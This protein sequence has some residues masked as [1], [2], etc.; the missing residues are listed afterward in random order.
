MSKSTGRRLFG[1]HTKGHTVTVIEAPTRY[2]QRRK[3]I[4]AFW[5]TVVIVALL[6]GTVAAHYM[7]PILGGLLGIVGGAVSGAIVAVLI[8]IWP[9]LRMIWHWL[10]EI[11]LA[12]FLIYGWNTLMFATPVWLSLLILAVLVGGPAAYGPTRRAV[13][14]LF[15]CLT[16]R[17]RLR[18]CFAAFVAHNRQGTLPFILLARPTPAGERVWL[19]LRPGLS[20]HDLEQPGQVQKLAVACWAN[21]V[22]VIRASRKYAPF[23]RV[24]ITRREPLTD[25]VLSTLPDHVPAHM[26]ATGPVSPTVPPRGVNLAEVPIPRTPRA[27]NDNTHDRPRTPRNPRPPAAPP[28]DF[29]PSD[30][31]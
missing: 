13:M 23:I 11:L 19:W 29:D 3:A 2:N 10:P 4:I 27:S 25:T 17:H 15:W 31:A 26:P 21:E 22:R 5:V 12:G 30:Y 16:V 24:D 8:I 9:V 18:M 14:S 1:S 6:G 28:A 7:H 20:L